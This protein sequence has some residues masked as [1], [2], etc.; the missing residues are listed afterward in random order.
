MILSELSDTSG[1]RSFK[2][3][4]S[5]S[6]RDADEILEKIANEL[7]MQYS[8][9]IEPLNSPKDK[10]WHKI[11]L[12]MNLPANASSELKKLSTRTRQ[13]FYSLQN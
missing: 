1:G 4:L 11:K 10:K 2:V 7:H 13:G 6:R 8:I 5:R 9:M 3:R 12:K